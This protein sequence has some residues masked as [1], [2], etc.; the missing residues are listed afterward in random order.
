[1]LTAPSAYRLLHVETSQRAVPRHNWRIRRRPAPAR[2]LHQ[3]HAG[4][5]GRARC[6]PETRVRAMFL[7]AHLTSCPTV[8]CTPS[9]SNRTRMIVAPSRMTSCDN[10]CTSK[11]IAISIFNSMRPQLSP[12]TCFPQAVRSALTHSNFLLASISRA[13]PGPNRGAEGFLSL[14]WPTCTAIAHVRRLGCCCAVRANSGSHSVAIKSRTANL[15]QRGADRLSKAP[16]VSVSRFACGRGSQDHCALTNA[17]RLRRLACWCRPNDNC[18]TPISQHQRD[19]VELGFG[20]GVL[21]QFFLRFAPALIAAR[22][23]STKPHGL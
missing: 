17:T 8:R 1:V 10:P 2:N 12:R 23:S 13:M 16:A 22:V 4:G 9:T 6:P 3:A 15:R 14:Y 11:K 21:T 20:R 7:C 18:S 19:C 5:A